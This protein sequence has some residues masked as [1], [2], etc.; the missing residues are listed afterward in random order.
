[1]N[2]ILNLVILAATVL[3]L[4]R[5]LPGVHIERRRTAV[6][7]AIVFSVVNLLV[8]WF[9]RAVLFIPAIM[10]LGLLFLVLPLIV[11]ATV[12]WLTD[13]LLRPFHLRDARTLWLS[14][15]VITGV[16]WVAQVVLRI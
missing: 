3:L 10:T 9:I 6:V 13:K 4:A 12:L 8:G 16:N 5:Y 14:A 15:L 2:L 7:V 11:N 1:M